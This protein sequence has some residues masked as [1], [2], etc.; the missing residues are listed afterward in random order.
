MPLS[1]GLTGLLL[2]NWSE[3]KGRRMA[4]DALLAA[5]HAAQHA[6]RDLAARRIAVTGQGVQL[7]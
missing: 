7:A 4:V 1:H 5:H 3:I 6:A 2:S